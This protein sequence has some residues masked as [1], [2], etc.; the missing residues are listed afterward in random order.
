[1]RTKDELIEVVMVL[2]KSDIKIIAE[3]E[4]GRGLTFFQ[5]CIYWFA[6]TEPDQGNKIKGV[7]IDE[8]NTLLLDTELG[9]M[10]ITPMIKAPKLL[11]P[12]LTYKRNNSI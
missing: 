4:L 2:R 8:H 5:R 3:L 7:R 1:M 11:N 10:M 12:H 9:E 6:S